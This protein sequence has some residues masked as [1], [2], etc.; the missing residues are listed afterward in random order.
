MPITN[1]SV[2]GDRWLNAISAAI[3]ATLTAAVAIGKPGHAAWL[4]PCPLHA[5][6]GLFCP[7]C[8]S[9]RA[10][11]Y[12][13]HGHP[14]AAFRENALA[15]LLLPLVIYELSAILGHRWPNFSG[16]LRPWMLWTL[17]AVILLFGVLRN[18]P[19]FPLLT[20]TDI[21]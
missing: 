7:G 17:L 10:L 18:L 8:G 2:Q 4:P 16:R 5:F 1:P 20:P 14:L 11:Y 13:V 15:L 3:L 12:L 6:I 19:W 21:P 9:T